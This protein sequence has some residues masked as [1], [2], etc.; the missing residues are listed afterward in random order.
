MLNL[1]G[2][3]A[4]SPFRLEKLLT[5][6]RAR[7]PTIDAIHAETVYFADLEQRLTEP[8]RATL[9]QLLNE[10]TSLPQP[11]GEMLLVVPRLGTVSPWSSK[12]TDIVHNCGLSSLRRVE[13]GTAYYFIG[14]GGKLLDQYGPILTALIHDR[15]TETVLAALDEAEALFGVAEP[16]VVPCA[17][18]DRGGAEFHRGCSRQPFRPPRVSARGLDR[19]VPNRAH[20]PQHRFGWGGDRHGGRANRVTREH[21]PE[22]GAADRTDST[23][24]ESRRSRG[25]PVRR[26][27]GLSF[28]G[29]L[30][31]L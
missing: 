28:G 24:C 18:R 29:F 19:R 21:E 27:R 6:S 4:L 1:R 22:V 25:K 17:D 9:G 26:G 7:V 8:Q 30:A 3:S 15:M 20:Q 31:E 16:Q 10:E 12:A 13:R 14:A 23:G 5:A 11:T 2:S